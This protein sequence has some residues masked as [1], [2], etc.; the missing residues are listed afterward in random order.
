MKILQIAMVF[1]PLCMGSIGSDAQP[2]DPSKTAPAPAKELKAKISVQMFDC[3]KDG[4]VTN[5]SSG[6]ILGE[7]STVVIG[8]NGD[9]NYV[10]FEIDKDI[11]AQVKVGTW[12]SPD[13]YFLT[14][15]VQAVNMK[16]KN[17]LFQNGESIFAVSGKKDLRSI[18]LRSPEFE[19][20]G[21]LK[22]IK[23]TIT[24]E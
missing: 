3:K 24:F 14:S 4:D 18:Q 7:Q 10:T 8:D 9:A 20:A 1:F 19:L 15:S 16:D 2:G 6:K 22:A 13:Q 12:G 17:L 11:I 5:C 23:A 21:S